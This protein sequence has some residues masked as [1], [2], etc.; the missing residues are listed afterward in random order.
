MNKT[1]LILVLTALALIFVVACT[2]DYNT[3]AQAAYAQS[4]PIVGQGCGV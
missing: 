3:G 1:R 2:N 4:Q